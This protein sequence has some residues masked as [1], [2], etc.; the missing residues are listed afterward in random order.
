MLTPNM[1]KKIFITLRAFF[2]RIIISFPTRIMICPINFKRFEKM[3]DKIRTHKLP[4]TFLLIQICIFIYMIFNIFQD[5]YNIILTVNIFTLFH[6]YQKIP[7]FDN[8][9]PSTIF[10]IAPPKTDRTMIYKM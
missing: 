9:Y 8:L 2:H 3:A 7:Q 10:R 1:A 5:L 6:C 4:I